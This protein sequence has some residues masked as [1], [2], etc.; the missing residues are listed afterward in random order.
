MR[1]KDNILKID[2]ELGLKKKN[3]VNLSSVDNIVRK[4]FDEFWE[5]IS[6]TLFVML[7]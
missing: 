4:I 6:Q 3:N 2:K 7:Y 1:L 5:V